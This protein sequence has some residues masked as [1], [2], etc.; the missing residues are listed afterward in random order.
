MRVVDIARV[1]GQTVHT[2]RYYTRI[3]LLNPSVRDHNKYKEYS[4][5]DL[6]RLRFIVRSRALGFSLQEI[7]TILEESARGES[8]C[9]G[10]R[11]ALRS[12][13]AANRKKIAELQALQLRMEAV[14]RTWESLPDQLPTGDTV[15]HLIESVAA[16]QKESSI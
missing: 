4:P 1:S 3:G 12:R 11:T 8:P 2:V 9:P 15:C 14:L 16:S 7:Q 13:I 10:V 6:Q 5:Q